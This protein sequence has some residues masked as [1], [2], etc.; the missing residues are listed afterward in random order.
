LQHEETGRNSELTITVKKIDR[1]FRSWHSMRADGTV[2]IADGK[3]PK[4]G[5]PTIIFNKC[6]N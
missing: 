4:T 5:S 1:K 6:R 3:V 2:L